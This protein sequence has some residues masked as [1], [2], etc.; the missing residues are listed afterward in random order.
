MLPEGSINRAATVWETL[1]PGASQRLFYKREA[2]VRGGIGEM[3]K[4]MLTKSAT[5]FKLRNRTYVSR[6]HT[7]AFTL[8]ELLVV[9]SIISILAALL[10]P[11]LGRA[12]QSAENVRC[13]SN[14]KQI[15]YG[16]QM[17]TEDGEGWLP[18]GSACTFGTHWTLLLENYLNAGGDSWVNETRELFYTCPTHKGPGIMPYGGY[19]P[20]SNIIPLAYFGPPYEPWGAY[21]RLSRIEDPS[22]YT[23]FCDGKAM[24][25]PGRE[26]SMY[27]SSGVVATRTAFRHFGEELYPLQEKVP[28]TGR[29]NFL[30][31][32]WHIEGLHWQEL[33][34]MDATEDFDSWRKR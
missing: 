28:G 34:G 15:G 12:R 29:A 13:T 24:K 6:K 10:V 1:R 4:E 27:L 32:D 30:F 9:I 18:P 7:F 25:W 19:I 5:F 3:I 17:Y 21:T 16:V 33:L 2:E 8:I 26:K 14:L 22:T 31:C 20:N 23:M 11:S